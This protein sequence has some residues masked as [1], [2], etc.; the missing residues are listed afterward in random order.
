MNA[1]DST[2]TRCGWVTGDPLYLDYHDQEWG[3]PVRDDQKLFEHLCLENAQAGLS[4]LTVLKKRENYRKAFAHFTPEKVV[5]FTPAK[6]DKLMTNAGLIRNRKKLEAVVNNAKL[7]LEIQEEFD[8]FYDYSMQ[9]IGGKRKINRWKSLKQVPAQTKESEAFSKDLKM[10]GFKFVGPT[11][12]Y[13]HMQ[14]CGMVHDHTTDCFRYQ[15][16]VK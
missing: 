14:A 12:M 5:R 2:L 7:F 13:A 16:L 9:F 4:W 6:V 11:I 10:R 15:E 1:L 3:V 8:S